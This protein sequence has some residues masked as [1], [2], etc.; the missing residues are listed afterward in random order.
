MF[1]IEPVVQPTTVG[2]TTSVHSIGLQITE[3]HDSS[4]QTLSEVGIQ[5]DLSAVSASIKGSPIKA[6]LSF[7]QPNQRHFESS[8][9]NPTSFSNI[10]ESLIFCISQ[11]TL[12]FVLNAD[13]G[14]E[15]S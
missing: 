15:K 3:S 8:T 6:F 12:L 14:S 7:F 2:R 4:T 13:Y 9:E 11:W 5:T 1:I 10:Y